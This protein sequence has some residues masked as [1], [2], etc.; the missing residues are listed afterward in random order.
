MADIKLTFRGEDYIIPE[1]RAF[2]V[3]ERVEEVAV[4]PEIIGWAKRP[5]FHKMARCFAEMLRAAGARVTDKEVHTEM[6][7][8]FTAG[9]PASYFGA[10]NALVSV[11]MDGAPQG[12]GDPDAEKPDAS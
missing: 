11:L 1:S 8:Q 6:M 4:L 3:G 7:G 9:N 12:K 10:L 5:K 2:E